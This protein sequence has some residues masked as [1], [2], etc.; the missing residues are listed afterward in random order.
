MVPHTTPWKLTYDP[1]PLAQAR[2]APCFCHVGRQFQRR[3]VEAFLSAHIV[4]RWPPRHDPPP[5]R[6]R[7]LRSLLANKGLPS[8]TES[9]PTATLNPSSQTSG[10]LRACLDDD[11]CEML[12]LHSK[13]NPNELLEAPATHE[14]KCTRPVLRPFANVAKKTALNL[15]PNNR[16]VQE[17]VR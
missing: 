1:L 3:A 5:A 7:A 4:Q 8:L 10:Q 2:D 12:P 17:L 13:E 9:S 15:R 16:L 6:T 14:A 11:R